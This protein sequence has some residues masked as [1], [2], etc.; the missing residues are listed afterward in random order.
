[1]A[2]GFV[3]KE[4]YRHQKALAQGYKKDLETAISQSE[5]SNIAAEKL[6]RKLMAKSS[7]VPFGVLAYETDDTLAGGAF[8]CVQWVT[9][10]RKNVAKQSVGQ[11]LGLVEADTNI[12][13]GYTGDTIRFG[14]DGGVAV[15]INPV[16]KYGHGQV[17]MGTG[18]VTEIQ[19]ETSLATKH[20]TYLYL[21]GV[22][23]AAEVYGFV[24]VVPVLKDTYGVGGDPVP[25]E[26]QICAAYCNITTKDVEFATPKRS[27]PYRPT[28]LNDPQHHHKLWECDMGH[29][30]QQLLKAGGREAA[31]E[32]SGVIGSLEYGHVIVNTK[33]GGEV[34][35]LEGNRGYGSAHGPI[36]HGTPE[37]VAAI[38]P[39]HNP[40]SHVTTW[41]LPPLI[42]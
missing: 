34:Y 16:A 40:P 10:N 27:I 35:T 13:G 31:S 18:K 38:E 39:P 12:E 22:A 15:V 8:N 2:F 3:S 30:M 42:T 1:M 19:G 32:G 33:E 41:A 26:D 14:G 21:S 9:V 11:H 23:P 29:I 24:M 36:E 4:K 20:C 6:I 25:L 37:M 5:A 17:F 28:G 7:D